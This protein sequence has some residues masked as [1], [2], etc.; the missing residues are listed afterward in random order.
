MTCLWFGVTYIAD[1]ILRFFKHLIRFDCT[2]NFEN[3]SS[4][5]GASTAQARIWR[6][7]VLFTVVQLYE[8]G[9]TI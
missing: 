7:V 6:C 5:W 8:E 2:E 1:W 4:F 3:H 9:C